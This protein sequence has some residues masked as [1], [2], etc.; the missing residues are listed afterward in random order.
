LALIEPAAKSHPADARL[1]CQLGV[2]RIRTGDSK[3][4]LEPL[5]RSAKAG[6]SA[7]AYLLAGATALELGEFQRARED[8]EN[9]VRLDPKIPGAWTWTGMARDRVSDEEGA[10]QAYRAALALDARDFEA[11]LHLGAILYRERD[12]TGAKPL[13]ERALS[14]QPASN[15]ARYA[16][17]LVQAAMGETAEAVRGLESVTKAE[18]DWLEPHVK[19]ASVYFRLHRESDARREQDVVE[20]LRSDHREKAVPLPEMR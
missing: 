4:S 15:L 20:K 8:L 7:D 14:L 3:G 1:Q 9:S 5:E 2:A 11:N 13:L 16:M 19:L 18:P 6:R 10:K 12:M 17:A